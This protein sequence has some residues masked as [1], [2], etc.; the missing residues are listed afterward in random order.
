MNYSA[1]SSCWCWCWLMAVDARIAISICPFQVSS[2]KFQ[3]ENLLFHI[4]LHLPL[5]TLAM[6]FK[7]RGARPLRSPKALTRQEAS[8][9]YDLKVTRSIGLFVSGRTL[10]AKK[11][12][13]P[14]EQVREQKNRQSL[15][16]TT[17]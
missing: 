16:Q 9:F 15:N 1:S 8:Y 6:C 7:L 12:L 5:C 4:V 13:G 17:T 2:F 3:F 14:E 10:G 11:Y